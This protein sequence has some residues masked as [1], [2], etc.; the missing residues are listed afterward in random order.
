MRGK[1]VQWIHGDTRSKQCQSSKGSTQMLTFPISF[2]SSGKRNSE[3]FE[4]S[5]RLHTV[6]MVDLAIQEW[7]IAP[8]HRFDS[9]AFI[10]HHLSLLDLLLHFFPHHV[11]TFCAWVSMQQVLTLCLHSCLHKVCYKHIQANLTLHF[12]AQCIYLYIYMFKEAK[13]QLWLPSLSLHPFYWRYYSVGPQ[14]EIA[15]WLIWTLVLLTCGLRDKI[16]QYLYEQY[17]TSN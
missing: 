17:D 9:K 16:W 3:N 1:L 13:S 10:F 4:S 5:G 11:Q 8:S 2:L 6:C 15:F 7:K 14:G 12:F